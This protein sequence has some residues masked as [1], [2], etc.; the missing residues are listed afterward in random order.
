L[1]CFKSTIPTMM[2][3]VII[4]SATMCERFMEV[5]VNCWVL[6]SRDTAFVDSQYSLILALLQQNMVVYER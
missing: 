6:K 3:T 5:W 1:Y 4:V 2:R